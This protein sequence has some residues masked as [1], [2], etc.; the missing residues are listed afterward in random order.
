MS[1]DDQVSSDERPVRDSHPLSGDD[2][3]RH[4]GDTVPFPAHFPVFGRPPVATGDCFGDYRILEQIGVGGMGVV[5]KAL[6][7]PLDKTVALKV[8]PP[9]LGG[10]NPTHQERFAREA[11]A[12]A[13]VQHPNVVTVF[14]AGRIGAHCFIE[15]EY[16]EGPDLNRMI[17]EQGRLEV[18]R[19]VRIVRDAAAG[20]AAAHDKGLVHRDVKPANILVGSDGNAKIVD[21]GLVRIGEEDS[22]LTATGSIFGSPHYMSPE[23][24]AGL[25]SDLRGD[26]YSLGTTF[27]HMLTGVPPFS[28]FAPAAVLHLHIDEEITPGENMVEEL[29][30]WILGV[31]RRMLAK[32][33]EERYQDCHELLRDLERSGRN[34]EEWAAVIAGRSK[35]KNAKRLAFWVIGGVA[36]VVILGMATGP[37]RR[38]RPPVR[39]ESPA[40]EPSVSS[41]A[42]PAPHPPPKRPTAG[43]NESTE[44]NPGLSSVALPAAAGVGQRS[45]PDNTPPGM[46]FIP[47]G[48]FAVGKA[49]DSVSGPVHIVPLKAFYIDEYETSNAEYE[50]FVVVTGR[51]PPSHWVEGK[52]PEGLENHPVVNVSWYDAQAFARWAGKRLPTEAEWERAAA[53]PDGLPFPWGK[54]PVPGKA[55]TVEELGLTFG[56]WEDWSE[57][58]NI[59]KQTPEGMRVMAAG[60]RTS[61]RGAFPEDRSPDGCADMVGNV[62]EWTRSW[63]EPYPGS[64]YRHPRFGT[65][66]RVVRGGAWF[67][68]VSLGEAQ[69]RSNHAPEDASAYMGFR[70]A[71]D[72]EGTLEKKG[73]NAPGQETEASGRV[74]LPL[75][76]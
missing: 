45:E 24:C 43:R 56:N 67:I 19:A 72:A 75:G 31:L 26:I 66:H 35:K 10:G 18:D 64:G 47:A 74:R 37:L 34:T 52:V 16:V 9:T 41:G 17:G 12:A 46:I 62:Y 28:G 14:R 59:W 22:S 76:G 4:P 58:Y 27:Y 29:P 63:F 51:P 25:D 36:A 54:R 2:A 3:R 69:H 40:M 8:L 65:T 13:R 55:N 71:K 11:R 70:C 38:S 21:F 5:Y 73:S 48:S 7:V 32:D 49:G 20:L 50:R 15:S 60:G 23:Q 68:G 33:P 53:G 39:A 30:A 57:W 44:G 1:G 6:N 61:P 42:L